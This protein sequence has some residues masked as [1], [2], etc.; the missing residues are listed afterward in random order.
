MSDEVHVVLWNSEFSESVAEKKIRFFAG[1]K[2]LIYLINI[3]IDHVV[4]AGA[5]KV[6]CGGVGKHHKP[7]RNASLWE[8]DVGV[9]EGPQRMI[10]HVFM[11]GGAIVQGRLCS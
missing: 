9:G 2:V 8:I 4:Q 5:E 1:D 7:P 3:Q 10:A 6:F 11:R